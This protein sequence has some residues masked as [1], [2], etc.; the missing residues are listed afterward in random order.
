VNNSV[1]YINYLEKPDPKDYKTHIYRNGII[2]LLSSVLVTNDYAFVMSNITLQRIVYRD[3]PY[4]FNNGPKLFG[5]TVYVAHHI[6]DDVI[7]ISYCKSAKTLSTIFNSWSK[8]AAAYIKEVEA[9]LKEPGLFKINEVLYHVLD[10]S[11]K[12][13][14][15]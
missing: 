1:P 10:M 11:I 4:T 8:E 6:P 3:I 5:I 2:S 13:G 15:V 12:K 9:Q 14:V 7:A